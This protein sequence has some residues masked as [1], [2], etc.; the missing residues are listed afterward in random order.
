MDRLQHLSVDEVEREILRL[1]RLRDDDD[2]KGPDGR[3]QGLTPDDMLRYRALKGLLPGLRIRRDERGN[4][5]TI[6]M[7]RVSGADTPPRAA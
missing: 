2:L 5:M 6:R 7:P 1:D 3:Q 4:V